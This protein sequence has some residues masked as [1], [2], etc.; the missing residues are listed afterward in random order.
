M[1]GMISPFKIN[2]G[3]VDESYSEAYVINS[4]KE[5]VLT[6]IMEDTPVVCNPIVTADNDKY[7]QLVDPTEDC[8]ELVLDPDPT[9]SDF[10]VKI[11]N[12]GFHTGIQGYFT[13]DFSYSL[14]DTA[15][16]YIAAEEGILKN[17]VKFSIDVFVDIGND[18]DQDNDDYIK[19]GTWITMGRSTA[20]FYLPTWTTEG[21]YTVNFR[22]I[23]V[24]G[25]DYIN[26]TETFAN[27]SRSNYV[28]TNTVKLEVSG[29][30]YGLT[31]YDISDYP[32]WEEAFRIPDSSEL[33][34]NSSDYKDGTG[35]TTYSKDYSYTYTVG[36]NDQYGNDTGRNVKYTFPLVNGSHPYYKNQGIL[37]TGYL[38]RF[39]L[40]TI[41]NMFSDA[42]SVVIKPS[43]YF[44]DANGGNRTA[45][46]L[47]YTEE[48]NNKSRNLV[49]V[50]GALDSTNIKSYYTG[51]LNLAIPKNEMKLTAAL[52]NMKYGKFFWQYSAM[53]T[54]SRIQ[55]NYAFRTLVGQDYTASI[56]KLSSYDVITTSGITT[57]KSDKSMQRWYGQYYIPNTV[58]V[59][60]KGYDVMDYAEKT[61]IDYDEDFWLT[62]G[63]IIINLN[64]YTIDD[65]GKKHLSY[66]NASNYMNNGNCS[67]WVMEGAPLTKTSYKGPTFNFYAGDFFI[68]YANQK[69]SDDYS[70]G[71]IY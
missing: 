27:Y 5:R 49:K 9:L 14:H 12:T 65:N 43:F 56:K 3:V 64:I 8:V 6:I 48:I 66:V 17:Q 39:S 23:A 16:S 28:A 51:N 45:V 47:Y 54:F 46:D 18:K 36:T 29:R 58:H 67:M 1:M 22:T 62:D 30:I 7:V 59:V 40:D 61:G 32:M 15:S 44:V 71:A 25:E 34:K 4:D 50:G 21:V 11:S 60:K 41:G 19:A 31:L 38:V 63:Y 57:A 13:R 52:R 2:A 10:T 70:S 53:F 68:Y 24:N 35:K 20:R 55:L 37:K 69:M 26:N 33:K 42:A